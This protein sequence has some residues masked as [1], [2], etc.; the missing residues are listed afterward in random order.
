MD[1][2]IKIKFIIVLFNKK[3]AAHQDFQTFHKTTEEESIINFKNH[4]QPNESLYKHSDFESYHQLHKKSNSGEVSNPE[5]PGHNLK[6]LN[7]NSSYADLNKEGMHEDY[8]YFFLFNFFKKSF[9]ITTTK[10]I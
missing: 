3:P 7:E 9:R 4:N 1:F 5:N 8:V 2:F 10:T 6:N